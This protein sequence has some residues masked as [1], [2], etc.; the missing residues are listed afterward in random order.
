VIC[1]TGYFAHI[2]SKVCLS[3]A[4]HCVNLTITSQFLN[5][6]ESL[7]FTYSFDEVIDFTGFNW[8]S[9]LFFNCTKTSINAATDFTF[10]YT[11]VDTATFKLQLTP[12]PTKFLVNENLC[13]VIKA[14]SINLYQYSVDLNKIGPSVYTSFL[15]PVWS[16]PQVSLAITNIVNFAA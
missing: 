16:T 9:F 2:P 8:Q 3:C 10:V 6:G 1:P 14:E 7:E 4:L 5:G 13:T 11:Q 15:C 12:I